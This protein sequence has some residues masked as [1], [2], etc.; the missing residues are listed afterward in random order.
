MI[1][2]FNLLRNN[3]CWNTDTV[4]E[5][6]YLTL[7]L[8][9][10]HKVVHNVVRTRKKILVLAKCKDANIIT[11]AMGNTGLLLPLLEYPR[12]PV[13]SEVYKLCTKPCTQFVFFCIEFLHSKGLVFFLPLGSPRCPVHALCASLSICFSVAEYICWQTETIWLS[14]NQSDPSHTLPF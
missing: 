5:N 14:R 8:I 3:I 6:R 10:S 9:F 7:Y 4:G 12:Y 11:M 13:H 1:T 2:L